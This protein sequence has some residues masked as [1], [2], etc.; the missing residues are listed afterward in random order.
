MAASFEGYH[1]IIQALI[2][3]TD[4]V[5][6]WPLFNRNPLP[7]WSKGRLVLLG[8]AC[9]PMKPHMAQG[10]AMAI[11]DAAMLTRC[12]QETGVTDF[13]T[14]FGLYETNR[15]D[16]ATR[17]QSVSN[18]NTFLLKQEDPAW[19]YGYDIYAEPLKSETAA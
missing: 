12:L 3:S 16:R 6:K 4:E 1:P 10:A 7:L 14:A 13:R 18:A 8:D 2:E 19:V 9:H 5:T 17:V 15:R 11:E